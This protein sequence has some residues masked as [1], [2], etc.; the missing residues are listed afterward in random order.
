MALLAAVF[1]PLTPGGARGAEEAAAALQEASQPAA[2]SRAEC[3]GHPLPR[4]L[5]VRQPARRGRCERARDHCT[6]VLKWAGSKKKLVDRILQRLPAAIG[7]YYEPFLGGGSVL[8]ALLCAGRILGRVFVGDAN[9]RLIN[10]YKAIRDN[11]EDLVRELA[12]LMSEACDEAT[13]YARREQFNAHSTAA[14]ML[15]LNATCK[16]GL[17]REN[18]D[19]GFNTPFLFVK[20]S[21]KRVQFSPEQFAERADNLRALSALLQKHDVQFVTGSW[22]KTLEGAGQG[23]TVYLDPPY[24]PL[25]DSKSSFTDYV[26]GG[27]KDHT[28]LLTW[29]RST[30]ARVLYSNHDTEAV[31]SPLRGW[32][33]DHFLAPRA[34]RSKTHPHAQ[35]KEILA[36]NFR[37]LHA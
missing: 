32:A 26:A 17:Y 29:A 6:A 31:V 14:L 20:G 1:P 9:P 24:E 10:T 25:A 8:I 3:C 11:V 27:F 4:Q 35:A 7:D 21:N 36:S 13:Y 2:A 18:G 34:I 33:I 5:A 30:E 22:T 28:A 19:G 12:A 15:F 16:Y 37:E 23:A